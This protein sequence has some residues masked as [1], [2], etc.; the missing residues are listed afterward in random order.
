MTKEEYIK[1]FKVL[2]DI[3]DDLWE[4]EEHYEHNVVLKEKLDLLDQMDADPDLTAEDRLYVNSTM[5]NYDRR[6]K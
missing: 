4:K 6:K 2:D 1:K 5:I 3:L